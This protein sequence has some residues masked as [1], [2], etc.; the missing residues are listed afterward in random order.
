MQQ[1]P[2]E[3]EV[4]LVQGRVEIDGKETRRDRPGVLVADRAVRALDELVDLQLHRTSGHEA[5]KEERDRGGD[6]YR[7]RCL[8]KRAGDGMAPQAAEIAPRVPADADGPGCDRDRGHVE[9]LP[10]GQ[11]SDPRDGQRRR[12]LESSRMISMYSHTSVTRSAN[13][14][15]HSM[16]FGARAATPRSMRSKSSRRLNAAIPITRTFTPMPRA[17]EPAI[18]SFR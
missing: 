8:E 12:S 17:P 14:P 13:A 1:A 15:Y 5:D 3:R 11:G 9:R 2:D 18:A 10:L 6:P 4:L 16:Y 7:Q